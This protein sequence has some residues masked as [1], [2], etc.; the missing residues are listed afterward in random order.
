V[1]ELPAEDPLDAAVLLHLQLERQAAAE[2]RLAPR[3]AL[4]IPDK[5]RARPKFGHFDVPICQCERTFF[6]FGRC[7]TCGA[8]QEMQG[9]AEYYERKMSKTTP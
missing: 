9:D 3:E 6:Y 4:M 7:E 2:H 8:F 5:P 1:P